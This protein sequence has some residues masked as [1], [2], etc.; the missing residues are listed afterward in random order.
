MKYHYV[1]TSRNREKLSGTIDAEDPIEARVKL[2]AMQIRPITLQESKPSFFENSISKFNLGSPVKLKQLIIFTRQLSSL[3]DSGVSVVKAVELLQEQ[4]RNKAFKSILGDVKNTIE[5]GGTLAGALE[6]YPHVFGEF[7]IRVVEAGE[8]SGTLDKSLKSV[9]EQL[10]KL[11]KTKAKVIKALTYPAITLVASILA[12]I[13]LLIKVIPEISKLYGSKKLPEITLIVL[14][15][16]KWFQDNILFLLGSAVLLPIIMTFTYRLDSFRD[17]WDPIILRFPLFGPL[18]VRSAVARF[19]R[20]LATLVASG[21]PLLKGFEICSKVISNRALRKSIL[22]ASTGVSEGKSIVEGLSQLGHFPPMVLH[23]I[24]IGEMTG[25]LDEL[26]SKV[27]EIYDDE[28]DNSVDAITSLLQPLL[29]M[30]VGGIILFLM[31]AMYMPIFNLGDQ[32]S[33]G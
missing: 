6:K 4:E 24:N 13:F 28:V 15:L 29:I 30:C 16:S 17:F 8:L 21:V 26:L 5:S 32:M 1:G 31:I 9:G 14:E 11:A 25:R 22:Q 2:R 23:M 3:I 7:F 33:A 20:T 10:E 18:A 27:A 12:V 19:S